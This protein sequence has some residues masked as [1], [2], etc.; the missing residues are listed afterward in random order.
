[1]FKVIQKSLRIQLLI[2]TMLVEAVMLALL[3][4]NSLRIINAAI[5]DQTNL[6]VQAADPLLNAATGVPLIERNYE[7]LIN[8]LEELHKNEKHNFNYIVVLDEQKDVY[9]Q[10]GIEGVFPIDGSYQPKDEH[11][12]SRFSPI[13]LSDE[14]IGYIYYGLSTASFIEAKEN[15]LQQGA[16]IAFVELLLSFIL[17]MATGYFLTRNLDGLMEQVV[18]SEKMSALGSLVAGVA[19]EINTPVG[20][21]LTGITHIQNETE[22]ML[23]KIE[24]GKLTKSALNDYLETVSGMSKTMHFSL[25]NAAGLVRS[26]KQ[27]AVDQNIEEKRNFNLKSYLNDVVLSLKGELKH[28]D[29]EIINSVDPDIELRSYAGVFA[30][31]LTNLIMNSMHHAFDDEGRITI[32][33]QMDSSGLNISY[34]DDGKGMDKDTLEKMFDPF[35]TTKMGQGGSGLG[36]NIIYNLISHKLKG[37][38][39]CK[40]KPGEGMEVLISVPMSELQ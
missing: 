40:S 22:K 30:Q 36:L 17:L 13:K 15:L 31:I 4:G 26:F 34:K 39:S 12:V 18:Q 2:F 9:A 21:S 27:V 11:I 35:F 14:T 10:V 3:L 29:I 37:A 38:I 16:L 6:R 7:T 8:M 33:G 25:V 19:H 32:K 20:V 5:E 1:M 23:T 24:E 28:T